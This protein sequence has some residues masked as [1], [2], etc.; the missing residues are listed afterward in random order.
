[1]EN[2]KQRGKKQSICAV[3]LWKIIFRI[4]TKEKNFDIQ[5][6]QTI[7]TAWELLEFIYGTFAAL[8]QQTAVLCFILYGLFL[9]LFLLLSYRLADQTPWQYIIITS[10]IHSFMIF[11]FHL[12]V[13]GRDMIW[14]KIKCL[15]TLRIFHQDWKLYL[16]IIFVFTFLFSGWMVVVVPLKPLRKQHA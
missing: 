10:F 3:S 1:M 6:Y 14:S 16:F 7:A 12:R 4:F 5:T 2:K 11:L 8:I 15:F 9:L 13:H